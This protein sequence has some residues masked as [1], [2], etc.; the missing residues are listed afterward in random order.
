VNAAD[1]V[2]VVTSSGADFT[3]GRGNGWG[4]LAHEL[5]A[6]GVANHHERLQCRQVLRR[7]LGGDKMTADPDDGDASKTYMANCSTSD[8][9]GDII[10]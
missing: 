9:V 3:T 10:G 7:R 8:E 4:T 6:I 2:G 1:L 5:H